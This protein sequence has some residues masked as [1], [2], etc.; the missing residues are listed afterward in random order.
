MIDEVNISKGIIKVALSRLIDNIETEVIIAGGGPAGLVAAK[1]LGDAGIKVTLFEKRLSPGGGMWGG[2][3]MLPAITVQEEAR[4]ILDIFKIKAHKENGLF[5]AGA[6]EATAKLIAGATDAGVSIFNGISVEDVIIRK[7]RIRGAVINWSA[8]HSS[9]LHVDP[10]GIAAKVLVD[11]TGHPAEVS[12][13]VERKVGRLN[14]PSGKIEGE[15]A[16]WVEKAETAVVENTKEVYPG[17]FVCGLAASAVFGTPRMGP[18]FGGMLLS[19][20]KA[21]EE[22]AKT[23]KS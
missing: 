3:M 5:I 13:C 19:G 20:K 14:T 10:L 8:V 12:R 23:L 22:I 7:K 6:I 15:G 2:G 18:I 16:M 11:A 4:E 9:G 1:F 17:L 21:A